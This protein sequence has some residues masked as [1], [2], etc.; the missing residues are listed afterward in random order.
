MKK[1]LIGFSLIA[2]FLIGAI[3]GG[4]FLYQHHL[5]GDVKRLLVAANDE[6]ASEME[7]HQYVARARPL[8]RTQ[9]DREVLGRFEKVIALFASIQADQQTDSEEY[10]AMMRSLS[11]QVEGNG[12]DDDECMGE[13]NNLTHI[14]DQY[15]H[16]GLKVPKELTEQ[17]QAAHQ[18]GK[19]CRDREKQLR[20][21]RGAREKSNRELA[22]R[23]MNEVRAS[24]GLPPD[25]QKTIA[26]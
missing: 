20:E 7:V 24:L 3:T 18:D 8:I 4:Y 11:H 25:S 9:R 26:P 14:R 15:E 5:S 12:D 13:M 21:A 1:L 17:V 23:T 10:R 6:H 22:L 16:A 2:L 19:E